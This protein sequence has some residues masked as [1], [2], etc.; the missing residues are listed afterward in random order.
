MKG[1]KKFM[2]IFKE[3][4]YPKHLSHVYEHKISK[5]YDQ[6]IFQISDTW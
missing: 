6:N 1:H 5:I 2:E 3:S 4:F